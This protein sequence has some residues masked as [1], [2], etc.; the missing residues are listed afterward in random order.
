M[1]VK[2][3]DL[4]NSAIEGD[5][6][7]GSDTTQSFEGIFLHYNT[8][9]N[10]LTL[11]TKEGNTNKTYHINSITHLTLN[12]IPAEPDTTTRSTPTSTKASF[13]L[14]FSQYSE[15]PSNIIEHLTKEQ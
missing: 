14:E 11:T 13:S 4:L 2:L 12:R 3:I 8:T 6:I 10:L 15:A 5:Q 1:K 7:T 9:Q